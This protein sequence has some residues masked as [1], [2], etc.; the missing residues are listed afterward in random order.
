MKI[1]NRAWFWSGP[2]NWK[3]DQFFWKNYGSNSNLEL[4]LKGGQMLL[5]FEA[6]IYGCV[7]FIVLCDC[8]VALMFM[9]V[10]FSLL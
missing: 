6:F 3:T 7:V 4:G 2:R 1:W 9:V 5:K 8:L 10:F